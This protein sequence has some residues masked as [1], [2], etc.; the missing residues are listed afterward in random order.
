MAG[1]F[2]N[3]TIPFTLIVLGLAGF[4]LHDSVS[5]PGSSQLPEVILGALL[6]ASGLMAAYSQLRLAVRR[7]QDWRAHNN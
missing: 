5:S 7:M 4:L 1:Y 2:L 3:L 6:F